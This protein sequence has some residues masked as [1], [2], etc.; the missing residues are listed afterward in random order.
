MNFYVVLELSDLKGVLLAIIMEDNTNRM[1]RSQNPCFMKNETLN[2]NKY[3]VASEIHA[4]TLW[5]KIESLYASKCW[6]NNLFL[7]NSIASLKFKE[8]TSLS[9]HLNEFQGIID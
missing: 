3:V 8:D 6:N 9:Y 5:E 4:R 1:L 2:I 7:L